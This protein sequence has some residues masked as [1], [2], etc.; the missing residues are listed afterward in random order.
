MHER[1]KQ[2]LGTT[3]QEQGSEHRPT[4]SKSTQLDSV[5]CGHANCLKATAAQLIEA[6]TD[7]TL[8][9]DIYLQTP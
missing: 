6:S 4:T 1:G 3:T 9:N 2:A 5:I 7:S 8:G